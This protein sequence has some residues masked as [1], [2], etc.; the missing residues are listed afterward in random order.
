[1][2]QTA[3]YGARPTPENSGT[4]QQVE[5]EIVGRLGGDA[6]I[7]LGLLFVLLTIDTQHHDRS[8]VL[9]AA[10]GAFALS[11]GFVMRFR[12]GRIPLAGMDALAIISEMII[13][14]LSRYGAP[15]RPALP[16]V[17][18][19]IGM[20]LFSARSTRVA[21]SHY[22]GMGL[23]FAGVLIVGPTVSAPVSRWIG[24]MAAV[25][26]PGIFV[27]W[28]VGLGSTL[29]ISEHEARAVA[30]TAGSALAVESAAKSTFIARMSHELRT[31]LNVV[32]GF[33]DLLAEEV[34]GPLNPRQASYVADI[35]D[36]TR[37]LAGL[38]DD[39]LAVSAVEAGHIEL[40]PRTVDL[41]AVLD[42]AA[43]MVREPAT[44]AQVR[45]EVS[46]SLQPAAV[47][48]DGRK[49][50]QVVVNLLTNAIKF[51]PPGGA[52]I[53]TATMQ[54]GGVSVAVRDEGLGIPPEDHERIFEQYA[55]SARRAEGS[56]ASTQGTGLG[57]PLS[58]RIVE[59]H[60]GSLT[61]AAS[62]PNVGS[63][64]IFE[65]PLEPSPPAGVTVATTFE[66]PA[67]NAAYTAFTEP[68]SVANRRL[69]VR[70]G[71]WLAW[72]AAVIEVAIAIATPLHTGTRLGILGVAAANAVSAYFVRRRQDRIRLAG[73][74]AWGAVGAV[75]ISGGAYYS[76][77]FIDLVPF[78]YGW[79]PMVAFAL[80]GRRRA[81]GHV[82]FVGVCFATV[83]A[84]HDVPMSVNLWFTIMTV[85]V[86]NG[87]VVSLLTERLRRLVSSEQ[88]ARRDAERVTS[89]LAT[90][91]AHKS[92]FLANTSHELR[93]PLNAIVGFA[94]LLHS[95][96]AGSLNPR[97]R[98]YV[99]DVR[100]SARR[101]QT[102]IDDVL[103][104]AKLEAGRLQIGPQLVAVGPLFDAVADRAR[105]QSAG[106][107]VVVK[108]DSD[109]ECVTADVR[110]LEQVLTN[111]A[112]NGVKFTPPGGSVE[113]RA[114]A[115]HGA[116][117]LIVTDTGIGILPAQQTRIFEPFH[118]G[119]RMV[120]DRL[121]EGTGLGLTLAKN[122]IELHGGR[123][124]VR[125][126]PDRGA[127]FT[128]ELPSPPDELVSSPDRVLAGS[129]DPA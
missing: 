65:L 70:V 63:I 123:I 44:A 87:A 101:L 17:Y 64:F 68:G 31:P 50:R 13:V 56:I 88:T 125:S 58:R 37:H 80:W 82:A 127:E 92:D 16:G 79:A 129:G 91:T 103:D 81:I 74:D 69:V 100:L 1:M 9:L 67:D 8:T 106:V 47:T 97:Q 77:S 14:A 116:V 105:Q 115:V 10:T 75:I 122:L 22:I 85:I 39:V 107:D 3:V 62:E 54:A 84:L 111:L 15:V 104:L 60:G 78:V 72:A 34:S 5:E 6:A 96:A 30:E 59:A 89:Q 126:S 119:T 4:L 38:V 61:L 52:V 120:N 11:A 51:T 24:L 98:T 118:Q 49:I 28:L 93:A 73:I 109:A 43:R 117:Q 25:A 32:L 26:V 46:R 33:T 99:D 18:V 53:A 45:I 94:D 19:V 110:R 71:S 29:A 102:V 90:A 7:C 108:I 2:L 23:S 42:E 21:L 35:G 124:T 76:G 48:A 66:S 41:I 27:R 112:V 57:L 113:L 55:T 83:L 86:F 121:P 114:K 40:H 12:P 20:I 95:E 36:S 128:V